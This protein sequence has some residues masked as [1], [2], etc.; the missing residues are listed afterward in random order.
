MMKQNLTPKIV[1]AICSMVE[2][3]NYL[4]SAAVVAGVSPARI[5]QWMEVGKE[6]FDRREA[7]EFPKQS[8][9]LF[10][11][12]Y[13]RV[14]TAQMQAEVAL[15]DI[16]REKAEE[17][18]VRAVGWILERTRS[19]RFGKKSVKVSGDDGKPVKVSVTFADMMRDGAKE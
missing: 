12:L 7:D 13:D 15:V 11:E 14:L 9:D 2:R 10:V 1:D 19:D 8:L 16:A 3:G 17:G 6:E 18:D 5:K 4:D